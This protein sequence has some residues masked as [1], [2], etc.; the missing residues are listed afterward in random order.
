MSYVNSVL[1]PGERVIRLGRLHWIMYWHAI[2]F[3]ALTV[4]FAA[5]GSAIGM[6]AMMSFVAMAFGV[7][8]VVS[9]VIV[10]FIRWT[11]EI[12]VTDR[13]FIYKRGFI[14]RHTVEVNMDKVAGVDVDQSILGRILDYG[15][16]RVVGTGGPQASS[17]IDGVDRVASPLALRN[18]ITA[19]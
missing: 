16:I 4:L 2:L 12:A 1:Q 14:N 13:R 5:W 8:T 19:K 18:A 10:W 17:G 6:G 3:A 7:L 15:T 11:T 9:F